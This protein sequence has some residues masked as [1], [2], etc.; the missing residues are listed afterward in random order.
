M[1]WFTVAWI[2]WIVFFMVVEGIA[3]FNNIPGDTL[4]E[5]VWKLIGTNADRSDWTWVWRIGL[6]GLLIWMIPHFMT[7]WKWFK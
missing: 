1:N 5:H 3:V 7:G 4:S 6:A 2:F